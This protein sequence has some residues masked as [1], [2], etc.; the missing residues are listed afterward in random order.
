M[1]RSILLA[2]LVLAA[3]A[4]AQQGL[5]GLGSLLGGGNGGA[6]PSVANVGTGNAAGLLGYCVRNNYL[7]ATNASSVIGRLTG[8]KG[9]TA[10]PGYTA[11]QSG[12][13]QSGGTSLPLASVKGQLKTRLCDAVLKHGTSLLGR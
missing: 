3:P 8:Q 6:L 4:T 2:A 7:S 13:L 12:I 1:T 9:V 10:S 5:G 11:G